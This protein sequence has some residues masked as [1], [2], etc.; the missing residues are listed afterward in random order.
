VLIAGG[1]GVARAAA[2]ACADSGADAVVVN[3]TPSRAEQLAAD[4]SALGLKGSVQAGAA[5][6]AD[7]LINCTPAGMR[8]GAAPNQVPVNLDLFPSHALVVDTVYTPEQTPLLAAAA[9][10]GLRTLSGVSMFVHQA[11]AQFSVWTGREAPLDLFERIVRDTAD[12]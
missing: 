4:L 6:P 3:R 8:D 9:A 5:Q 7:I 12:G 2:Y 11:A 1:G 10:R